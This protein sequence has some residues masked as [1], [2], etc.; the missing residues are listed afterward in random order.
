MSKNQGNLEILVNVV[1]L[2]MNKI[3]LDNSEV[4]PT[5]P[6]SFDES[7]NQVIEASHLYSQFLLTVVNFSI[8]CR[9]GLHHRHMMNV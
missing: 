2:R 1:Y 5:A 6:P 8:W 4:Y 9:Q 3:I 7:S